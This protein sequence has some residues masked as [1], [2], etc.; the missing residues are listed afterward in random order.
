MCNYVL[1]EVTVKEKKETVRE[2][3]CIRGGWRCA[4]NDRCLANRHR[5]NLQECDR[6][7]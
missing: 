4:L 5:S 3:R 6:L 1:V 7:V 2:G